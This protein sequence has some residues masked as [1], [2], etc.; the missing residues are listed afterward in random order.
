MPKKTAWVAGASGL[1]GGHLVDL[2]SQHPDYQKVVALVR[3]PCAAYWSTQPS[4]EQ[5]VV[6][7]PRLAKLIRQEPVDDLFCALGSTTRKTPDKKAYY[8]IDVQYPLDF[9][10]LGIGHG[11]RFYGL[12]SAYGAN[13]NSL[14]YYFKMKGE[15]EQTIRQQA[16]N[17][18]AI[19]QPGMLRGQR[20]E[21]RLA[22]KIG[23]QLASFL[24]GNYKAIQ[25][26]DVAAALIQAANSG[27]QGTEI[28]SSKFMQRAAS[29]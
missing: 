19:A 23:G 27:A 18:I 29:L 22:E 16:F 11:A 7:F 2:L 6:D 8:Q 17:H 24:P 26:K 13:P 9:A 14:S 25:A 28:L 5:W 10:A 15:L 20:G 4:V 1:I 21:F 12:V 3:K